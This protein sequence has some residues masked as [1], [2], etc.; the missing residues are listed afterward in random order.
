MQEPQVKLKQKAKAAM[1]SDL[2]RFKSL[3]K[4]A[5]NPICTLKILG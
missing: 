1:F 4:T 2:T 3:L 5:A